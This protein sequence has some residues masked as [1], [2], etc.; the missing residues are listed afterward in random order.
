MR[1]VHKLAQV[2]PASPSHATV[3]VFDGVHRGHQRLVSEMVE[4]ARAAGGVAVAVTFDPHPTAVLGREPTPLLTP[5]EERAALL[6][7]L[8]LDV[9]VVL[10]FT[11]DTART[12]AGEFVARLV[13]H[14]DLAELWVGPDFALG[15]QR[16]GDIDSLRR[17]GSEQGFSVHAVAPL[18]WEGALV[19]SSRV[20]A[21]LADGDARQ[22][23]GCLGRPYRLSGP[24]VAGDGRG[25]ELGMPTANIAPPPRKLIPAA[26][27][28]AGLGHTEQRGTYRAAISIGTRPTFDGRETT[29]EAHLLGFEGTL[30]GQTLA[31]DLVARLR[32]EMAFSSADAL[33]AQMRQDVAQTR[34][35]VEGIDAE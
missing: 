3:G 16:E 26:G 18:A 27:V 28:Y 8:E 25:R 10:P 22:A 23:A 32:D 21:A 7:D 9:L 14:L 4:G 34:Q 19:S 17:L 1:I 5:V 35:V 6:S 11:A 24:V 31:L 2:R 20:R 12:P 30:Y 29:V 13:R 15:H 33:V